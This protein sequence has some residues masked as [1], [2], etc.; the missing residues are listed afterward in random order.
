MNFTALQHHDLRFYQ[1]DEWSGLRHGIFTRHGGVSAAPFHS[2]NLGGSVGDDP[3]AVR[4][5]HVRMYAALGVEDA[6]ACTVWQVHSSDIVIATEPAPDHGWLAHADG[7]L[8]DKPDLP[9]SM[10]FADCTPL[11]FHDPTRGVIGIA[12]AG[13]RGTVQG[14]GGKMIRR[15]NETYGCRPV[16]IQ[17]VIGPSIG[18][19]HYQVGAE[20]LN[21][22]RQH[23]GDL[24]GLTR[25]LS[26][27]SLSFDLWAANARDLRDAGA[28]Q[29]GIMQI[30]T[31]EH[32]DEW[33]SHRGEQ[34]HTGRFGAVICL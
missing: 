1:L 7:L 20:V 4:A 6:R 18:P 15:M 3:A 26:D 10:R 23:F 30:C 33:F 32:T 14:I 29:I 22:A 16:D 2:L 19:C 8:T 12:H 31:A 13:W 9:L 27:G 17:A 21:A 24:D 28:E 11:L 34:G 25:T 5:N